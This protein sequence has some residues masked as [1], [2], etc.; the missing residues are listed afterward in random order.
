[1]NYQNLQNFECNE[2]LIELFK[3]NEI[4]N[5]RDVFFKV[6]INPYFQN[7]HSNG[8]IIHL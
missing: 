5:V 1:M 8:A 2:L 6:I 7:R 3:Y 4:L